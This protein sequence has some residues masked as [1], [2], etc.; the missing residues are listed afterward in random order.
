MQL[1]H[2]S[3]KTSPAIFDRCGMV[4]QR[5][6]RKVLRIPASEV[7]AYARHVDDTMWSG[8]TGTCW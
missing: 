6:V 1:L 7:M 2:F 8:I 5:A 3:I 4:L